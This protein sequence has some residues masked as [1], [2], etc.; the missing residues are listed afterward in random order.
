[1]P[2]GCTRGNSYCWLL[3][4]F[5]GTHAAGQHGGTFGSKA[6]MKLEMEP[7]S[8]Q[9]Y[10]TFNFTDK[11][12]LRTSEGKCLT[13]TPINGVHLWAKPL[14]EASTAIFL[15]NTMNA[16]QNLSFPLTDVP[17]FPGTKHQCLPRKCMA[18]NVWLQKDI[19]IISDHIPF[20]FKPY[21]SVFLILRQLKT[22]IVT[23]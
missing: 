5:D 22:Q 14:S 20:E 9:S 15:L 19:A 18:R 1:M 21:E 6:G 16:A 2:A 17:S 12:E 7:M 11:A 10:G 8:S 4:S 3:A 23:I 13:A